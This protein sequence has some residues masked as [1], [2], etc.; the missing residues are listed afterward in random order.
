MPGFDGK[1][2]DGNGPKQVNKGWPRRYGNPQGQG[3]GQGGRGRGQGQGGGGFG[4][5]IRRRDG[6][7]QTDDRS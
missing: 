7:C 2:P 6:S 3:R 1:G 4:R 5:G